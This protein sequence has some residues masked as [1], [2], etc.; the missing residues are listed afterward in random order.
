MYDGH[1][2]LPEA[3]H[4]DRPWRIH[5]LARDFRLEDVWALPTLGGPDDFPRLVQVATELDPAR[6]ASPAVR[7]LFALRGK[8]GALLRW[9]GRAPASALGGRPCATGCPPI[10]APPRPVRSSPRSRSPRS[11]CS[12]RSSPPSSPTGPCT[13]SCTSAGSPTG[14]AATAARWRFS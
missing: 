7:S 3:A 9:D 8:L 10:C 2:R 14:S 11:T 4:R 13:G 5:E 6:S 1:M 12:G